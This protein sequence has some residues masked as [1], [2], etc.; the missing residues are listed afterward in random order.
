MKSLTQ[1]FKKFEFTISAKYGFMTSLIFGSLIFFV[2]VFTQSLII[3][4]FGFLY[5]IASSIINL[6]LLIDELLQYFTN[7]EMRKIHINSAI[8]ISLNIPIALLYYF[9]LIIF[10]F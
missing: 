9:I 1:F 3:A 4:I 5:V 6:L 10:N 8:L 2:F 7:K